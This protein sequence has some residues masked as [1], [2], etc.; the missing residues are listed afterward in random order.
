MTVMRIQVGS[1]GRV[2]PMAIRGPT[3]QTRAEIAMT[4]SSARKSGC[5]RKRKNLPTPLMGT[6]TPVF[7][8][9]AVFMLRSRE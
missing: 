6:L 4:P 3:Y 1:S 7:T 8:F 5:S 9:T 2:S